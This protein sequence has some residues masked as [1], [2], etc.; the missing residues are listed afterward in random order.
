MRT[1]LLNACSD[2]LSYQPRDIRL[3]CRSTVAVP[4]VVTMRSI[5]G[6]EVATDFL[7]LKIATGFSKAKSVLVAFDD[8]FRG[9][10]SRL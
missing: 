2:S 4:F 1:V 6:N 7:A 3:L 9:E 8:F 10:N 5:A